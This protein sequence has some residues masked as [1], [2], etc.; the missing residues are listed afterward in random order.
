MSTSVSGSLNSCISLD[1]TLAL[2]VSPVGRRKTLSDGWFDNMNRC[3]LLPAVEVA[4]VSLIA[5]GI[6]P[7]SYR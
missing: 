1:F 4:P 7:L 3:P 6:V 5:D 2:A